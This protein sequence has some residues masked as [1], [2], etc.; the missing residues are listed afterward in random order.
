MLMRSR[1]SSEVR[2]R[3]RRR[4]HALQI[5]VHFFRDGPNRSAGTGWFGKMASYSSNLNGSFLFA[6]SKLKHRARWRAK[7]AQPVASKRQR[8]LQVGEFKVNSDPLDR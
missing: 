8:A 3:C 5:N 4:A 6:N 7:L 1:L 2:D